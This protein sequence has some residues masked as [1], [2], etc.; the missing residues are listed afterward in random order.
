[1]LCPV[2]KNTA[3]TEIMVCWKPGWVKLNTDG[4]YK[5]GSAAG[6][7]G[8]IQDNRGGCGGAK[9]SGICSAYVAELRGVLEGLRYA[10]DLGFTR[11]EL[12]VDSSVVVVKHSYLEA[13]KCDDV[14]ANIGCTL[15]SHTMYYESCP[16]ECHLVCS[17]VT[18]GQSGCKIPFFTGG[19]SGRKLPDTTDAHCRFERA[20]S[21]ELLVL[22]Y[23]ADFTFADAGTAETAEIVEA[24]LTG[25]VIVETVVDA[26]AEILPLILPF[27]L[28]VQLLVVVPFLQYFPYL[29]IDQN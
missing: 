21:V 17:E 26:E 1:M 7:G 20:D 25:L 27:A 15:D 6:C 2:M 18:G 16:S 29:Q 5:D 22:A 13:N 3:R 19:S 9:Y 4:A 12:N 28:G 10:R 14:L 24:G 11:I 8:V 23:F